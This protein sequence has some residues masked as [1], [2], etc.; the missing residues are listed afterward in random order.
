[1]NNV[2]LTVP[3]LRLAIQPKRQNGR[4]LQIVRQ[5]PPSSPI[6]HKLSEIIDQTTLYKIR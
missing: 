2:S 6:Q 3:Q 4:N 1:M 5:T